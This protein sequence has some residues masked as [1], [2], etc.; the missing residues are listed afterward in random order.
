MVSII[1][2]KLWEGTQLAIELPLTNAKPRYPSTSRG[3][4][5]VRSRTDFSSAQGRLP[6]IYG[7]AF[8]VRPILRD[9]DPC[10]RIHAR[11]SGYGVVCLQHVKTPGAYHGGLEI[12][13]I[14]S[15]HKGIWRNASG[16]VGVIGT[17]LRKT[18]ESEQQGDCRDH[19]L[20]ERCVI[21]FHGEIRWELT[22]HKVSRTTF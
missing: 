7:Q 1:T 15:P 13:G 14:F 16:R 3:T 9:A 22:V 10:A 19:C 2:G 5:R 18:R 4:S 20:D 17:R 11:V 21:R 12:V 6:S 8:S